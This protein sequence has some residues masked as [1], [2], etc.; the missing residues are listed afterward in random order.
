MKLKCLCGC[1]NYSVIGD[2]EEREVAMCLNC[3]LWYVSEVPDD[4][5]DMYTTG[6][7]LHEHQKE[8]GCIPYASRYWHDYRVAILRVNEIVKYKTEGLL[9]DVGC[10]NGSL[11][12]CARRRGFDSWGIDLCEDTNSIPYCSA[13]GFSYEV[14]EKRWSVITMNDV[15]EHF[16]DPRK[17][18][19][20]AACLL[21]NGGLLVIEAPDFG[22]QAFQHLGIN[23]KHVRP[24]QHIYMIPLQVIMVL[25][26][27][28]GFRIDKILYP[29]TDHYAV[30]AIKEV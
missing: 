18:L 13:R 5:L 15:V 17:E 30:Y 11:V 10:A 20:K 1:D 3:G 22:S 4:Y 28:A 25:L 14:G 26:K 2:K 16:L 21:E 29:V 27:E 23:W 9:L 12:H 24:S 19:E 6:V 7:Y 8:W